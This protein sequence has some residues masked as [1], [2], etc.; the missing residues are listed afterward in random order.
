MTTFNGA[1]TDALFGLRRVARFANI[2]IDNGTGCASGRNG[3][4]P[5]GPYD[6]SIRPARYSTG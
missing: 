6:S 5:R 1:Y 2:A 4:W 3:R